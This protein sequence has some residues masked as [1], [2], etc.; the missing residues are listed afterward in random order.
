M[1]TEEFS[2]ETIKKQNM[3]IMRKKF[4]LVSCFSK[5]VVSSK[6]RVGKYSIRM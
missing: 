3:G 5:L 2:N 4:Y 6:V 1:D